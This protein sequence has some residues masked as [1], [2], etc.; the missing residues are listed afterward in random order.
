ERDT[1]PIL[2]LNR[3]R[4]VEK[5][6]K[7]KAAA[8]KA[9]AGD[10]AVKQVTLKVGHI[11]SGKAYIV[12]FYDKK[13]GKMIQVSPFQVAVGN[14]YYGYGH[15]FD[16][17]SGKD[18]DKLSK[19]FSSLK[20]H[21]ELKKVSG[22]EHITATGYTQWAMYQLYK[23]VE[24][25]SMSLTAAN[26]AGDDVRLQ[27]EWSGEPMS[28]PNYRKEAPKEPKQKVAKESLLDGLKF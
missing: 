22:F 7:G 19:R 8:S 4:R 18:V 11:A 23:L 15:H 1:N 26:K 25:G 17:R 14:E 20:S 27:V 5:M 9:V 6:V 13:G 2:T 16:L 21:D 28:E 24:S 12:S 10:K 3:I